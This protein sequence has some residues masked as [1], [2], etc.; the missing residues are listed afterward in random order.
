MATPTNDSYSVASGVTIYA[1]RTMPLPAWLAGSDVNEWVQAAAAPSAGGLA[2]AVSGSMGTQ[3]MM[4]NA[5]CGAFEHA[6]KFYIHGGGHA[7][8]GGNEV[9][10]ADL[11]QAAPS[12]DLLMERT[13]VAD[14]LGGSNYYADG[15]PTSRHTYYAMAV[16]EIG[17]V[18]TMLRFNGWMGFAYNGSPVGGSADVRT[19]DIDGLNLNTGAWEPAAYGPVDAITGSETSFAQDPATGDCYSWHTDGTI[20]KY[21]VSADSCTEVVDLTGTD[22]GGAAMVFDAVNQRLVRFAGRGDHKCTYWDAS[23]GTKHTPTLTGPDA[24]DI[25]GLTGSNHGWGI[26]HDTTRNVAYLLSASLTLYR[27]RL[28]DWYV[29]AI[30]TTGETLDSATNGCWGKLKY[31]PELDCIAYLATWTSPLLAM[32]CG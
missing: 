7:D 16:A 12:W 4:V 30:T 3:A 24:G 21:D 22:G 10:F 6:G 29:E 2:P 15:N 20:Q 27:I 11:L 13:P 25:S 1:G 28:D 26:A 18:P 14:L 9:G 8:Y 19:T 17:G 31:I 5:W 23:A 32:R